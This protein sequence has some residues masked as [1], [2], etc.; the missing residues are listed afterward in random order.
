MSIDQLSHSSLAIEIFVGLPDEASH[1][2][3]LVHRYYLAF[4]DMY[5][6]PQ[7]RIWRLSPSAGLNLFKMYLLN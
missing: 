4:I 2:F 5:H 6:V 1:A 7:V 3:L